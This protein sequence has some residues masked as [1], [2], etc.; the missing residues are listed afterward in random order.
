MVVIIKS[1]VKG[2]DRAYD[3]LFQKLDAASFFGRVNSEKEERTARGYEIT[4]R[5]VPQ[6]VLEW[7]DKNAKWFDVA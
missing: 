2:S 6:E 3:K 4:L 5:E 1:G 7:L